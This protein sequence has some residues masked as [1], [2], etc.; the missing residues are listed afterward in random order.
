MKRPTARIP[1]EFGSEFFVGIWKW[2][3]CID[4]SARQ[5]NAY[6]CRKLSIVSA[7]VDDGS[8]TS[9]LYPRLV[10]LEKFS[11][12]HSLKDRAQKVRELLWSFDRSQS[13]FPGLPSQVAEPISTLHVLVLS[14]FISLSFERW[15]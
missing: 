12:M 5:K 6:R 10:Y 8:H 1:L 13:V 4:L 11:N 9:L 7:N 14:S 3:K 2:L 15:R